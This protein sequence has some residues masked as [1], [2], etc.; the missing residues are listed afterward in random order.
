MSLWRG[1]H[2]RSDGEA[3]SRLGLVE[4]QL[5]RVRSVEEDV[6][7]AHRRLAL[8]L[9]TED[10]VDPCG[11]LAACVRRLESLAHCADEAPR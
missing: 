1:M 3:L 11:Q 10:Q 6:E 7:R 8:L 9:A 2:L 4:L 5:V